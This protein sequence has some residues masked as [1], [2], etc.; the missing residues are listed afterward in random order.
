METYAKGDRFQI[1]DGRGKGANEEEGGGGVC[2]RKWT[3]KENTE[4]SGS[5]DRG[6]GG[7]CR[8][9]DGWAEG[10]GLAAPLCI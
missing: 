4:L 8:A 10:P 6:S 7:R 3:G 1:R 2:V 9:E 5:G